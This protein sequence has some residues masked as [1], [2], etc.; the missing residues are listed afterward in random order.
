ML[1]GQE[2]MHRTQLP[3]RAPTSCEALRVELVGDCLQCVAST[4]KLAEHAEDPLL[5][6]RVTRPS[7]SVTTTGS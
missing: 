3:R 7:A 6:S 1:R 5:L 4:A 2:M